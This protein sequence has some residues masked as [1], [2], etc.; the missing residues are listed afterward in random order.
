[1]LLFI[2][3]VSASA[4]ETKGILNEETIN[5][6]RDSFKKTPDNV[7]LTNAITHNDI[8]KL[9]INRENDGKLNHYFSDVVETKAIT[10]QNSSGRCWLYTGLNTLRPL[11]QEEYK[12]E[13]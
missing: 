6:L 12:I 8:K 11:V 3:V 4:Q 9:A 5:R 10:N 1:M 13:E 7:A 2:I